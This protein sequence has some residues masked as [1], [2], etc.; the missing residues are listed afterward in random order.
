MPSRIDE[1]GHTK[2][3]DYP[4]ALGGK[5]KCSVPWVELKPTTHGSGVEH[6]T[7]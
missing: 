7:N 5:L 2:V 3:F 4:V 1:A 6:A